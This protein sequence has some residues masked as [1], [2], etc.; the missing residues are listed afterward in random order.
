MTIYWFSSNFIRVFFGLM[1]VGIISGI[2]WE[3]QKNLVVICG[4]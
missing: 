1:L 3:L 4:C 2:I